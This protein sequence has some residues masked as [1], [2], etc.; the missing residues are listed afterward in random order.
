MNIM[1]RIT[2]LSDFLKLTTLSGQAFKERFKKKAY[3][4][5]II[6]FD[7]ETTSYKDGDDKVGIMYAFTMN[8]NHKAYIGRTWEEFLQITEAIV[9]N[10]TLT[11]DKRVIIWVHNLAFEFQFI[12]DFFDWQEVFASDERKVIYC[13]TKNGLEFRCSYFLTGTSLARVPQIFGLDVQKM[14]GDLDYSLIRHSATPL[15]EEEKGYIYNDG[16][17][18]VKLI[19]KKVKDETCLQNLPFTKTSYVRR[20]VKSVC[21]KSEKFRDIMKTST[22]SSNDYL[23]CKQA[24]VGGFTHANRFNSRKVHNN[25]AS[26]DLTSDYPSQMI[27]NKYPFGKAITEQYDQT[28]DYS[29]YC[30]IY[31]IEMWGV[32]SNDLGDNIISRSKCGKCLNAVVDNGRIYSA[33][34]LTLVCTDIDLE[35][36]Q[37]F[38]SFSTINIHSVTYWEKYYLPI[39]FVNAV[40]DLYEKKTTLKGVEERKEEYA[41]SKENLNSTFGMTVTDIAKDLCELAEGEWRTVPCDVEKE[42]ESYNKKKGRFLFYPWGVWITAYARRTLW[43]AIIAVGKD[44]YIYSDTDSV[45]FKNYEAHKEYFENENALIE[46]RLKALASKRHIELSKLFPKDIKGKTRVLGVW[47]FEGVYEK[48]KTLGAKRY[49]VVENDELSLTVSGLNKKIVVPYLK[50]LYDANDEILNAFDDGLY[51]P[52]GETGKKTHTYID[53]P[54]SGEISD[55]LGN[56]QQVTTLSGVHLEEAD[57]ELTIGD[58]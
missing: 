54:W 13:R 50:R 55:Y 30:A 22:L 23:L 12:K 32:K 27:L 56:K 46:K 47:D 16:E 37:K 9:N 20:Y 41:L 21:N 49:M 4:Q 5:D 44:D 39:E 18:V 36:I 45:K 34:Y 53:K 17:I 35:Y 38:Y 7:I 8:I 24:F 52:R 57:Y 33:D 10:N 58:L 42:I 6:A 2:A 3:F 15:T 1:E 51:I 43:N 14:V 31:T 26:Y 19:E 11:D 28:K 48:F 40:L 25:V 29:I